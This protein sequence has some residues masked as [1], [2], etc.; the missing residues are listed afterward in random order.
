MPMSCGLF[1]L[2]LRLQSRRGLGACLVAEGL[3]ALL[4]AGPVILVWGQFPDR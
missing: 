4:L 2:W 3:R 1:V